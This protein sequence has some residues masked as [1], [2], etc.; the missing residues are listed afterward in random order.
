[1]RILY[2]I[3]SLLLVLRGAIAANEKVLMFPILAASHQIHMTGL[4]LELDKQGYNVT[5]VLARG[6]A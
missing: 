5:L 6:S 4:A 1:M 2:S 3:F